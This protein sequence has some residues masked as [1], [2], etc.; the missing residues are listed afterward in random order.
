M[1]RLFLSYNSSNRC[2]SCVSPSIV[3]RIL[4]N[5]SKPWLI[6]LKNVLRIWRIR[7]NSLPNTMPCS[8]LLAEKPD[9]IWA[10]QRLSGFKDWLNWIVSQLFQ[11]WFCRTTYRL[12][13][14]KIRCRWFGC[15]PAALACCADY[16]SFLSS[17]LS[18]RYLQTCNQIEG[19][20]AAGHLT[21]QWGRRAGSG[22]QHVPVPAFLV[23]FV[24]NF[25]S[26]VF[27]KSV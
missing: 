11:N 26:K 22:P 24:S 15:I 21:L 16:R 23:C 25:V 6:L 18:F 4:N 9:A 3:S 14:A 12:D 10:L 19:R 13:I 7:S 20:K 17:R 27:A 8:K 5:N 1:P 2:R